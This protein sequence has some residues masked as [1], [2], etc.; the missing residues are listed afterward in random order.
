MELIMKYLTLLAA[1]VS[2]FTFA[3]DKTAPEKIAP[4]NT[5]EALCPWSGTGGTHFC[6]VD[7]ETGTTPT[8]S[9]QIAGQVQVISTQNGAVIEVDTTGYRQ[10]MVGS[11][12][13]NAQEYSLHIGNSP[14]NNGWAGDSGHFSNDSEAH[15][16]NSTLYVYGNDHI[17]NPLLAQEA[18]AV[19]AQNQPVIWAAVCDGIF[20]WYSYDPVSQTGSSRDVMDSGLFQIDGNEAD[21]NPNGND[22]KL[23]IGAE[24]T[25]GSA[26]RTGGDLISAPSGT[27]NQGIDLQIMLSQ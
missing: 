16:Y 23:Y 2:S 26:A 25:I 13:E 4:A 8:C 7:I 5:P 20:R 27:F 22:R 10:M 6:Y 14:S 11:R 24:R 9:P 19:P 3:A 17:G 15:L 21:S 1:T 18:N 12:I